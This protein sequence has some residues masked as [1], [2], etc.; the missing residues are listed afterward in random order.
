MGL[1]TFAKNNGVSRS[2]RDGGSAAGSIVAYSLGITTVDPIKYGLIFERFLN[3]ERVSM[4][5][6]DIDF[7][8]N[9]RQKIIDYVD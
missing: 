6:I 7:A 1:H 8:P 9:G 2:D 5:D 3:P 4:P